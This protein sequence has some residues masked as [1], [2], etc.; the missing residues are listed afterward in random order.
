M[1]TPYLTRDEAGAYLRVAP[2]TI[3]RYAREG[4]IT[5]M[6]LAGSRTPRFRKEELDNLLTP[7]PAATP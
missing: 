6:R 4:K 3:D 1:T 5:R 2:A 7:D